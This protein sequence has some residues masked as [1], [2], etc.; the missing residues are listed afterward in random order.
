MEPITA[1]AS[2]ATIISLIASF[3]SSRDGQSNDEYKEFTKWLIKANHSEIRCLLESNTNI[4]NGVKELLNQNNEV[5]LEK[6]TGIDEI[7]ASIASNVDGFSQI[8]K[9]VRPS[10]EI[11]SQA[12]SILRQFED[13]SASKIIESKAIGSGPKY[14]FLDGEGGN[15]VFDDPRFI[16]DDFTTLG[17]LG[18][19]RQDSN[20]QGYKLFIITRNGSKLVALSD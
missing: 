11:S 2:F 16:E 13:K 5:L 9:A 10:S 14:F 7:L 15:L 20:S 19:L 3:K 4:T 12:L 17:N 8:A 18:L 1:A 6:L